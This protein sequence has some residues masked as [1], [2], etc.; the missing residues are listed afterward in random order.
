[1]VLLLCVYVISR[2]SIFPTLELAVPRKGHYGCGP[3]SL[4]FLLHRTNSRSIPHTVALQLRSQTKHFQ[5]VFAFEP[6][7]LSTLLAKNT[8]SRIR[9]AWAILPAHETTP[10]TSLG[11][12]KYRIGETRV[13]A[14]PPA[15]KNQ[16]QTRGCRE[17]V[18]GPDLPV[19][20]ENTTGTMPVSCNRLDWSRSQKS[21][22]S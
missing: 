11:T 22:F 10:L 15:R 4:A 12:V 16:L 2:L 3:L 21:S 8:A 18:P 14:T 5:P 13:Q 17:A 19:A 9:K 1:M 6:L 20:N 7:C